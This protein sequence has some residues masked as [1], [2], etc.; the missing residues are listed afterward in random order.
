[1][2]SV[3]FITFIC[4]MTPSAA[5][6]AEWPAS[7][8]TVYIPDEYF[9]D[10]LIECGIDAN[11]NGTIEYSETDTVTFV[12]VAN[13]LV[14]DL[15]GIEAFT[16]LRLLS[17]RRTSLTNIDLSA[18]HLLEVVYALDAN[19]II[20]DISNNPLLHKLYCYDNQLTTLDVSNHPS[21]ETLHCY[22]NPLTDIDVTDAANLKD[23]RCGSSLLTEIEIPGAI[24]LTRL[25]ISTHNLISLDVSGAINLEYLQCRLGSLETLDLSNNIRLEELYCNDNELTSLDLSNNIRLKKL[26]CYDN[27]LTSLILP[28][29]SN[30]E[31]VSCHSNN[32]TSLVL[33]SCPG[34][35]TLICSINE[36]MEIDVSNLTSLNYFYCSSNQLSHL[37][38][39]A[40]TALIFL[41]CNNN[42]LMSI[43]VSHLT[44]FELLHCQSNLLTVVD[45]SCNETMQDEIVDGWYHEV[46]LDCSDNPLEKIRTHVY[47][48]PYSI[49]C[50]DPSII[51]VG[52]CEL[53]SIED[54]ETPEGLLAALTLHQNSPN[55]FNPTTTIAFSLDEPGPVRLDVYDIAGRRIETLIDQSM[56]A[57]NHSLG[58]DAQ[59]WPSGAYFYKLI[60]GERSLTKKMLLVK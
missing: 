44:A 8:D 55:P 40:N 35:R 11:G 17:C 29:S 41:R 49:T 1:M 50:D 47:P 32:L 21:L 6:T 37:D 57:G 51:D 45:L 39:T 46:A 4:L 19:L 58:F 10:A 43:D 22:G 27:E 24:S 25:E 52:E 7:D 3:L 26:R 9:L 14:A 59:L 5:H 20:M 56:E 12:H 2:K 60:S 13:R 16:N 33:P 53:L 30:L 42:Q 38:L 54:P 23:L 28:E 15:T 31:T 48:A 36:L 34:L 18:N